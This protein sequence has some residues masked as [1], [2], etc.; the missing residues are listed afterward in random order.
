MKIKRIRRTTELTI[1]RSRYIF[2]GRPSVQ[3]TVWCPMCL[4]EARLVTPEEASSLAR[5]T[6]REINRRVEAGRVHF[7]ETTEGLLFICAT[8]LMEKPV[9]S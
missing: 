4:D 8:S 5:V 6:V 7:I 9:K 1:E 3:K 2:A